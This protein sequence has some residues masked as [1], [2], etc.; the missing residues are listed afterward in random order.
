MV[1][2]LADAVV[3]TGAGAGL[4]YVAAQS[5]LGDA[6]PMK[7]RAGQPYAARLP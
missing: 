1:D 7:D 2:A 6:T 5:D 4:P 3:A